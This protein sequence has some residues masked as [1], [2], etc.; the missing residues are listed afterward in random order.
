MDLF[1]G[2]VLLLDHR[3][4]NSTSTAGD[5][6][7]TMSLEVL[8]RSRLLAGIDILLFFASAVV[9]TWFW[10]ETGGRINDLRRLGVSADALVCRRLCLQ[11]LSVANVLRALGMLLDAQ[12]RTIF[13]WRQPHRLLVDLHRWFDYLISSFPTLVWSSMLSV[14]L[15]YFVEAYLVTQ[16][17]Q[18]PLLRPTF[19]FLNAI[20][21]LLYVTIAVMTLRPAGPSTYHYAVFR[22]FVYFLLGTIHIMLA[23]GLARYGF[24]LA[25]QLWWRRKVSPSPTLQTSAG[26]LIWR[27]AMLSTLLPLTE[28]ARTFNDLEYSLG[29][30]PY[31]LQSGLGSVLFLAT[32]KLALEWVPS[33]AILYTFRPGQSISL[34]TM[35]SPA[36]SAC[37]LDPLLTPGEIFYRQ[38]SP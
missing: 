4:P 30:M 38:V 14:L 5:V 27:I 9:A 1:A 26:S 34:D 11:L 2:S 13:S 15:L 8:R 35:C 19:V 6:A 36:N 32:A 28:L 10:I 25:A 16:L 17:R 24:G 12:F 37:W 23:M 21:Y 29:M 3:A 18:N 22:H 7:S 31:N 20:A 33:A